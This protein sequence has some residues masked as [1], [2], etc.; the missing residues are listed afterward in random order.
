MFGCTAALTEPATKS[1]GQ[2][3]TSTSSPAAAR[4]F[5]QVDALRAVA[6]LFVLW[7]H[8]S[9]ALEH[10][11]KSQAGATWPA[12]LAQQFD[13]GRIGV[14]LFFVI[15]GFVVPPSYKG[16]RWPATKRFLW[17][18]IWRLYPAFWLSILPGAWA[19]YWLWN[20]EFTLRDVAL[21]LTMIPESFGAPM[22]MGLYWT[23]RIEWLFYALC[24]LL[25]LSGFLQ[26]HRARSALMLLCFAVGMS[27]DRW[28]YDGLVRASS[29]AFTGMFLYGSCLRDESST[30]STARS[31]WPR[32]CATDIYLFGVCILL[33]SE[34]AYRHIGHGSM[35]W[36]YWLREF[37]PPA[38]GVLLFFVGLKYIV[39]VPRW[40][41][42][43]GELTF[44]IYLLHPIFLHSVS[45]WAAVHPGSALWRMPLLAHIALI[46]ALTMCAAHFVY[47][48]VELPAMRFGK[49]PA[50]AA[51]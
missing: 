4:R 33:P 48:Y 13:F 20:K 23:L 44:S 45:Y 8:S 15:S 16:A 3:S 2:S 40:L 29:F 26:S 9:E 47:E 17:G 46:A 41:T 49:K 25:H 32:L 12:R 10:I 43:L 27:A 51:A 18:R 35:S 38:L 1:N 30:P 21:N 34:A 36:P 42:R 37:V 50:P 31:G 19:S 11:A 14:C 28:P 6:A 5:G 22:A 7:M 39:R 24:V